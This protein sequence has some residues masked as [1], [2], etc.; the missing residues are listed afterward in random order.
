[1]Y[2]C[3]TTATDSCGAPIATYESV[4]YTYHYDWEGQPGVTYYYR[5][6]ACTGLGGCSDFSDYDAGTRFGWPPFMWTDGA[7]DVTASSAF[8]EGTVDNFEINPESLVWFEYG[9]DTNY[10]MTT[11]PTLSFGYDL[12]THFV[13]GLSCETE[14]HFRAVGQN[15]AGIGY[16]EDRTFMT[17][18]C[19]DLHSDSCEFATPTGVNSMSLGYVNSGLDDKDYFRV[20]LQAPG[21]LTL[22]TTGDKDTAG[23]IETGYINNIGAFV[24]D[25]IAS[26][27]DSGDGLNFEIST[28][29]AA[30][31][32]YIGV[33]G[34]PGNVSEPYELESSFLATFPPARPGSPGAT[35]GVYADR[36]HLNWDRTVGHGAGGIPGVVGYY[37][38]TDQGVPFYD[39][40]SQIVAAKGTPVP[41]ET[42][43]AASL[44][45]LDVL[46]VF[47]DNASFQQEWIDNLGA[48][49][50]A[51]NNGLVLTIHD[52]A[53]GQGPTSTLVPGGGSIN[54]VSSF[55]DDLAVVF[56][57]STMTAGPGGVIDDTTL[58]TGFSS[59]HGYGDAGS[60]PDGSVI[61]LSHQVSNFNAVTFEYGSGAGSVI[62]SGV[63]L[64]YYLANPE[65][66][67]EFSRNYAPNVFAYS[68]D[69]AQTWYELYRCA[70]DDDESSC[71]PPI[72]VLNTG[73]TSYDDYNGL[74]N[75]P[76][77]YRLKVC[78]TVA[79]CS[80]FSFDN[81]GHRGELPMFADGFEGEDV[82]KV[83]FEFLFE[84]PASFADGCIVFNRDQLP[85]PTFFDSLDGS[86]IRKLEVQTFDPAYGPQFF[87]LND[88]D[89]AYWSTNGAILDL[90]QSLIGQPTFDA[91]WGT[92][93]S[94]GEA[95][96]FNL[97]FN[98]PGSP[99]GTWYFTLT[100]DQGAGE[101]MTLTEMV[102]G[103]CD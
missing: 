72:A 28:E 10:G 6:K 95:G 41:V 100:T 42:P 46:L 48:V 34:F 1:V 77:Y 65:L 23:T 83:T 44:Q 85:N 3:T 49:T 101:E 84:G 67:P 26:D 98:P 5:V 58:D 97:F 81:L 53:T 99:F 59:S 9:R 50:D 2:R 20:T 8:L 39:V 24:C 19:P 18:A 15:D 17:M 30:G 47:V 22:R 16:G 51:V 74:G 37:D 68:L 29:L 102:P 96:D 43:D 88:L 66:L 76:Y 60:L 14:Y 31:V 82:N 103:I 61:H 87:T 75:V 12:F 13:S 57:G 86:V 32:Y 70:I 54:F 45:G 52:R 92:V 35:R 94:G 40:A 11:G 7:F 56:P 38:A 33:S 62:Y 93:P 55:V 80:L 25:P 90:D 69:V 36:V 21:R 71:G 89:F 79:G 78:N 91:P 27:D 64:D 73:Q 4:N 63:P